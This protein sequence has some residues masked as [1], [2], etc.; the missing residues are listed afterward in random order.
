MAVELCAG[1][2]K[3]FGIPVK[4]IVGHYEAHNQGYAS[5][6]GDPRTWMKKHNDSM[7]AFRERVQKLLG[8]DDVGVLISK[9]SSGADVK[10]LQ[11][12][13]MKAGYDLPKYG[14]DGKFGTEGVAALKKFQTDHGLPDTGVCN[15]T[16]WDELVAATSGYTIAQRVAALE[17]EIKKLS[18]DFKVG[19]GS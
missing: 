9:G 1:L 16:T 17:A 19:G 10:E 11:T 7:D 5:N 2:C 6:H 18:P 13:L 14:A 3:Q 4:N 8:G 12:M 15:Q